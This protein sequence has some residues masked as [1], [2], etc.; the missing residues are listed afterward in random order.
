MSEEVDLHGPVMEILKDIGEKKC[1][2]C[3]VALD[4]LNLQKII[5]IT[6]CK[7]CKNKVCPDCTI[8]CN[9][10]NTEWCDSHSCHHLEFP[11][12]K[13]FLFDSKNMFL[14]QGQLDTIIGMKTEGSNIEHV[15]HAV[16]YFV[17]EFYSGIP[18]SYKIKAK[19]I[20]KIWMKDDDYKKK[21]EFS[22]ECIEKNEK[23]VKETKNELEIAR[24]ELEKVKN[25]YDSMEMSLREMKADYEEDSGPY[26]RNEYVLKHIMKPW[27]SSNFRNKRDVFIN[28]VSG[29]IIKYERGKEQMYRSKPHPPAMGRVMSGSVMEDCSDS[30]ESDPQTPTLT[31]DD[32]SDLRFYNEVTEFRDK[33]SCHRVWNFRPQWDPMFFSYLFKKYSDEVNIHDHKFVS[34]VTSLKFINL[35]YTRETTRRKDL[36]ELMN[37]MMYPGIG[38]SNINEA[39][40]LFGSSLSMILTGFT[41]IPSEI[42]EIKKKILCIQ[43]N[44]IKV[45]PTKTCSI[46][47]TG[48]ILRDSCRGMPCKHVFHQKCFQRHK[49]TCSS[50]FYGIV[51]CPN[52]RGN[53]SSVEYGT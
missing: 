30:I 9:E 20:R 16:K 5:G 36:L 3:N 35:G 24:L 4:S 31:E 34:I 39:I 25:K 49:E 26:K 50:R 13:E 11:T 53:I 28:F 12:K 43:D 38:T 37:N 42:S 23:K 45:F 1:E 8:H 44:P 10:C 2:I 46:C 51:L 48:I 40:R 41:M 6:S 33:E 14:T 29:S 27:D 18:L 7:F 22:K 52:C 15:I 17:N 21:M 19:D 32:C 47:I